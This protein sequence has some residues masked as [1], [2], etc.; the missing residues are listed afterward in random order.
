M[1]AS[2]YLKKPY[3]LDIEK[4]I[5]QKWLQKCQEQTNLSRAQNEQKIVDK[6]NYDRDLLHRLGNMPDARTP[7]P[8]KF[9]EYM[10]SS[11]DI[12]KSTTNRSFSAFPS[13]SNGNSHDLYTLDGYPR[14]NYKKFYEGNTNG[15]G[16]RRNATEI[17]SNEMYD[18]IN[19]ETYDEYKEKQKEFLHFNQNTIDD[20]IRYKDYLFNEKK[21]M[22]DIRLQENQRLKELEYQEKMN[23]NESKKVYRDILDNQLKVKIP[24]KLGN[25]YYNKNINDYAIKFRNPQL[26]TF[27]PENSFMNRN[28]LVEINPYSLKQ[29]DLGGSMLPHNPIINPVFD[30]KYNK[31]LFPQNKSPFQSVAESTLNK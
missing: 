28:K 15:Y 8:S 30:Y 9:M 2:P 31:Y 27:V 14:G 29:G 21:R 3:S 23:E 16:I 6:I 13:N 11:K 1:S 26:Y 20:N 5:Y 7:I 17:T 10:P 24:S 4:E 25:D 12:P 19:N 22:N 18:K